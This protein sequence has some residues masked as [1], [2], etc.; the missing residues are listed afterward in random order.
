MKKADISITTII[1]AAIALVVLIVLIAI[2]TGK[3]NFFSE[4]VVSCATRGGSCVTGACQ[5][6]IVPNTECQL[7][8][9]KCCIPLG[10]KS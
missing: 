5:G 7:S 1:V 2:F 9:R 10:L 6:P 3:I 4:D 8:N